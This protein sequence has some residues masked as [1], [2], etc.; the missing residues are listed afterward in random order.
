MLIFRGV[1]LPN[2]GLSGVVLV[3]GRVSLECFCFCCFLLNDF[4]EYDVP[5]ETG[6][7]KQC[8]QRSCTQKLT[9]PKNMGIFDKPYLDVPG[10]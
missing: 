1:G 7:S 4:P 3:L 9:L 5:M 8:F 10:S 2:H 6:I